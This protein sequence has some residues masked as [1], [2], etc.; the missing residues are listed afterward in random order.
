VAI[1]SLTLQALSPSLRRLEA[2]AARASELDVDRE[3]ELEP[4]V[5]AA[6]RALD[7]LADALEHHDGGTTPPH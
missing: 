5:E 6:C 2:V 4:L 7:E 1:P 3:W